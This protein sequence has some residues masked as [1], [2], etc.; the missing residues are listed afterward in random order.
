MQSDTVVSQCGDCSKR[1]ISSDALTSAATG[2]LSIGVLP[3]P[4]MKDS[5][6]WTSDSEP[7]DVLPALD[8]VAAVDFCALATSRAD[9]SGAN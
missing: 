2:K 3:V 4:P 8:H 5:C 9:I 6:P 7:S 1:S